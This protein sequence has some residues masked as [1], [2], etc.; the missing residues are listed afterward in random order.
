MTDKEYYD[1]LIKDYEKNKETDKPL[2]YFGVTMQNH[3][4]Y[5]KYAGGL[6]EKI[7]SEYYYAH[8]NQEIEELFK[9]VLI[10]GNDSKKEARKKLAEEIIDFN[11]KSAEKI[12]KKIL[13]EI[14][15]NLFIVQNYIRFCTEKKNI[16]TIYFA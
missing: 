2:F 11:E 3:S 6:N 7:T 14:A 13:E 1:L 16:I 15:I 5:N 8:S 9:K 10:E 12:F 4:P